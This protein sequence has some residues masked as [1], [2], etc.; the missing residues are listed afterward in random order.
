VSIEAPAMWLSDLCNAVASGTEQ[1]SRGPTPRSRRPQ[2]LLTHACLH[3][4]DSQHGRCVTLGSRGY[5]RGLG[6]LGTPDLKVAPTRANPSL[7]YGA[8][9]ENPS[10]RCKLMRAEDGFDFLR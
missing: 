5:P 2:A 9:A 10:G 1:G 3:F 6:K 4:D 8:R 7:S